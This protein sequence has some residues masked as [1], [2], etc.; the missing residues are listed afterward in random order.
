MNGRRWRP[1]EPCFPYSG[2]AHSP[3][4]D[5]FLVSVLHH[6]H[7]KGCLPDNL[8]RLLPSGKHD[9]DSYACLP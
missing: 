6:W 8:M 9:P 2:G 4:A 5:V 7:V 3:A 1:S